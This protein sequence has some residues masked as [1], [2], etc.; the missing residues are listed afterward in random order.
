MNRI[1]EERLAKIGSAEELQK[2]RRNI[3]RATRR[4]ERNMVAEY[5]NAKDCFSVKDSIL[6]VLDIA[7]SIQ[8]VV[9]YFRRG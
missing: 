7:D 9:R 8:S 6:Y 2:V 4:I 5:N 1:S 3:R